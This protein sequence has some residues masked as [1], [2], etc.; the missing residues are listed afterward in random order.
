M[1]VCFSLGIIQARNKRFQEDQCKW[2]SRTFCEDC[3]FFIM[4][5]KTERKTWNLFRSDRVIQLLLEQSKVSLA[6]ATFIIEINYKLELVIEVFLIVEINREHRKWE[7]FCSTSRN[8]ALS[9]LTRCWNIKQFSDVIIC[10][11]C[12]SPNC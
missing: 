3:R 8:D 6:V 9:C 10:A 11:H 12:I 1:R 4:N 5:E 2:F 7:N